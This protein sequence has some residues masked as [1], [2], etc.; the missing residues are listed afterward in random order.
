MEREEY[1]T[2][3][4]EKVNALL[5]DKLSKDSMLIALKELHDARNGEMQHYFSRIDA[6]RKM[7]NSGVW[8]KKKDFSTAYSAL[9]DYIKARPAAV[10]KML[11][12]RLSLE[13][14]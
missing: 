12:E 11:D 7:R 9:T 8:M 14:P 13:T 10:Q 3:F 2:Y 6:L 1:R 5:E 4:V